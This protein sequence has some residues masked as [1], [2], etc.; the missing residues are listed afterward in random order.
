MNRSTHIG[1]YRAIIFQKPGIVAVV[2]VPYPHLCTDQRFGM[3]ERTVRSPIRISVWFVDGVSSAG[4]KN[5]RI[6][7]FLS[8]TRSYIPSP[9]REIWHKEQ[10]YHPYFYSRPTPLHAKIVLLDLYIPAAQQTRNLTAFSNSTFCI[11][12]KK[13]GLRCVL[14]FSYPTPLIKLSHGLY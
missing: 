6:D 4:R 2:V 12:A 10:I 14:T 11:G 3:E 1:P 9:I 7:F 8:F 5:R 13:V